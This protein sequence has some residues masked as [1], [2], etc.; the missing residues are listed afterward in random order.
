MKHP[1]KA[2]DT[3]YHVR[4]GKKIVNAIDHDDMSSIGI[5]GGWFN[6]GD[7][8]FSPWPEPD[9]ERPKPPFVPVLKKGQTLLFLRKDNRNR[10]VATVEVE[11]RYVVFTNTGWEYPKS[12]YDF[13]T[14]SETPISLN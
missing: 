14:I 4:L 8:S 9:W 6:S 2:G 11:K 1:F 13:Y 5:S 3:V 7:F 12:E 10:F